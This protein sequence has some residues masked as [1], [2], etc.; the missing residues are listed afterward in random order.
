MLCGTR[1]CDRCAALH[2]VSQITD[3]SCAIEISEEFMEVKKFVEE[4]SHLRGDCYTNITAV[5]LTS[6]MAQRWPPSL[7]M[8]GVVAVTR[9][10]GLY[11]AQPQDHILLESYTH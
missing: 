7:A 4:K 3:L 8:T 2:T 5:H 6:A 11:N 10:Y 1:A 9:H